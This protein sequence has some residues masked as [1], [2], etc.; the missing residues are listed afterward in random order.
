MNESFLL[1]TDSGYPKDTG[2]TLFTLATPGNPDILGPLLYA[3]ELWYREF[4]RDLSRQESSKRRR[5]SSEGV[6]RIAVRDLSFMC[7][8]PGAESSQ[9]R[10]RDKRVQEEKHVLEKARGPAN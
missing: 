10:A 7:A 3:R 9:E 5:T 1:K 8:S 4:S 6:P 2:V